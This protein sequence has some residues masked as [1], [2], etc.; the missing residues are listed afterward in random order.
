MYLTTKPWTLLTTTSFT[1]TILGF[2]SA[3]LKTLPLSFKLW[4]L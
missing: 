1:K 3:F 2:S 4:T